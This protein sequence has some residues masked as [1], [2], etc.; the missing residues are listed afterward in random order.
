MTQAERAAARECP[1]AIKGELVGRLRAP[2]ERQ[3]ATRRRLVF[4]TG[5]PGRQS[6]CF[7]RLFTA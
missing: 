7:A 4:L 6:V 1:G 5:R 2:S 3:T